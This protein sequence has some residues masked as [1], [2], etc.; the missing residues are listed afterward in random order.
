MPS[1]LV[2]PCK[3]PAPVSINHIA[4]QGTAKQP[5]TLSTAVVLSLVCAGTCVECVLSLLLLLLVMVVGLCTT[6]T[7]GDFHKNCG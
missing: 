3:A 1:N 5:L 6:Q 4:S 7:Q 2:V